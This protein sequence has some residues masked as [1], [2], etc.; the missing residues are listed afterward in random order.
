MYGIGFEQEETARPQ[1]YGETIVSPVDNK[2]ILYFP[3]ESKRRR[4]MVSF[5]IMVICTFLV[6]GIVAC[7]YAVK[8]LIPMNSVLV[9]PGFDGIT[10]FAALVQVAVIA[11]SIIEYDRINTEALD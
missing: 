6:I 7:I 10:F 5:C 4:Q 2:E 3:N 1:F 8:S 11:V 9:V